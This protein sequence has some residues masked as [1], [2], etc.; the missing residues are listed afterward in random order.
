[1]AVQVT[2]CVDM[3]EADCLPALYWGTPVAEGITCSSNTPVAVAVFHCS[4]PCYR[5][6]PTTCLE[7]IKHTHSE[8]FTEMLKVN[9]MLKNSSFN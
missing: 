3:G 4:N 9:D 6:L 8:T 2:A 5:L 7:Y 1:M